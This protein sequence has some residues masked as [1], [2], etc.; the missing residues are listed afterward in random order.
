M[1]YDKLMIRGSSANF[2]PRGKTEDLSVVCALSGMR[3]QSELSPQETAAYAYR[4]SLVL[5]GLL[6]MPRNALNQF[7]DSGKVVFGSQ[8]IRQLDRQI[9][10][11][12]ITDRE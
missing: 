5:G 10:R 7:T 9:G 8:L 1:A 3:D 6:K 11:K 2:T 4:A 12:I